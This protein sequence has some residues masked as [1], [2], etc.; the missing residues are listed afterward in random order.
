MTT[1]FSPPLR[2]EVK[3]LGPGDA[4]S[5]LDYGPDEITYLV[6]FLDLNG[7]CEIIDTRLVRK[8]T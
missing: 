2:V 7:V 4:V 1:S 6:V 8:I 3:D 5:L